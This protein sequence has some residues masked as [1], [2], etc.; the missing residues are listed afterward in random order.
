MKRL[1]LLALL[2]LVSTAAS[3]GMID[4]DV[5]VTG[6]GTVYSI[7]SDPAIGGLGSQLVLSVQEG[8][9]V[10]HAIVPETINTG[11]N[12]L[13]TLAFDADSSTL[14]LVWLH[15]PNA[16]SSEIMVSSFRAGR[17]DAAVS[18]DSKP[19]LIRY[20]LSVGI[21]RR[22]SQLQK[23]G[24]YADV[25]ALLVHAVW[26]EQS[27]DGESARYALLNVEKGSVRSIEIHDLREFIET[28]SPTAVPEHNADRQFIR[29]VAVLDGP[30]ASSVDVLFANAATTTFHRVTLKPV[31]DARVRIPVGHGPG[32][33]SHFPA[34]RS[35]ATGWAGRTTTVTSRDGNTIVFCNTM[36][37]RVNY[38]SYS[39]S[40]HSWSSVK[41]ISLTDT[42]TA[43]VAI[44]ALARMIA[45]Q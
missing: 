44:A 5:L 34:P 25:P 38:L 43:D 30:D 15:S 23:D 13:P 7:V 12:W 11:A 9:S 10:R 28:S 4:R 3:A 26:W 31:A 45:T 42:V 6:D 16:M 40:S 8:T 32:G 39:N 19:Y 35:L 33:G 36:A 29:H 27:G 37:G 20:N 17:W 14:F 1:V 41:E 24:T 2:F 18:I 22:V 21:T